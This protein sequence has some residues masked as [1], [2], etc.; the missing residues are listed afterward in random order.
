MRANHLFVENFQGLQACN[1]DLTAPITLVSGPNGA[2]KSS[3]QEALQAARNRGAEKGPNHF[4]S[5]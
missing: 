5:R 3:L 2:G 4:Q 1:L